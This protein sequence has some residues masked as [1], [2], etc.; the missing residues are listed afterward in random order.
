[1][2]FNYGPEQHK[3]V[4]FR[5][6]HYVYPGSTCVRLVNV[7]IIEYDIKRSPPEMKQDHVV[8]DTCD[9]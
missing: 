9:V 4:S 2:V 3:L 7:V 5:H 6:I 8:G 1:M